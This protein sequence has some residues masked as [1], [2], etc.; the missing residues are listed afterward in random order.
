MSSFSVSELLTSTGPVLIT[1]QLASPGDFLLHQLLSEYV[2]SSPDGKCIII[3][4][5]QDLARWKAISS[6]SGFNMAQKLEQGSIVF[7]DVPTQFPDLSP[8]KE[9]TLLPLLNLIRR[10]IGELRGATPSLLIFDELA[11]FQWIGHSELDVSRFARA[12]VASCAK[13]DVFLAIRYHIAAPDDLD[14]TV[15]ILLQ[16][17]TYHI[18]VLPLSSGKSGA[19]SGEIALHPGSVLTSTPRW[20]IS[21]SRALQYRLGEYHATYFERGT[22]NAVL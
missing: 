15:R 17:S 3:S 7:V 9:T 5:S 6:R 8:S 4:T 12:L 20:V 19:V 1:D 22:G 13:N 10:Y 21:R 2:K 11:L 16:L 14:N 18:E